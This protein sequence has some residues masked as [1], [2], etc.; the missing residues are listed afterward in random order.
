MPISIICWRIPFTVGHHPFMFTSV[1]INGRD[2]PV[3]WFRQRLALED[4]LL[5]SVRP[6]QTPKSERAEAGDSRSCTT[7]GADADG[8]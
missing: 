7:I 4:L 8:M 2:S 1:Q 3:G 5:I 6:A